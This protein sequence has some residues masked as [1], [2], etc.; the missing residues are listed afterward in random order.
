MYILIVDD[1]LVDRKLIKKMLLS[2]GDQYHNITEVTSVDEGLF[3]IDRTHFDVILLD[4]SMPKENGIK[5][6]SEMRAKPNLGNTAIVMISASE[7]EVLAL[8]C[9]EAGAQDFLP[10]NS[11]TSESLNKAILFAQKRFE[12]EQRMHESYLAVKRMAQRDQLT[13]LSNRY[14]FEEL[15]KTTIESNK[16][17][18]TSAALLALDLDNFKHINDTLGHNIGDE[19]LKQVVRRINNCLRRD[20]GFARLGGDEFAV[21]I[22]GVAEFTQIGKIAERILKHVAEPY[23]IENTIINCGVSIGSAIY[24]SDATE[25]ANLLKCADI[26][27][28]RSK[29][30]GKGR[31]S[32]YKEQYQYEFSRR[33]EIQ[34]KIKE[35]IKNNA[36]RL[37]YQPVFSTATNKV[38]GVEALIR[39]PDEEPYYTP[40]EF[41]PISEQCR[42]IDQLG[43]WVIATALAQLVIWQQQAESFSMSIN[44]S[45]VQLQND[46]LLAYFINCMDK[47]QL[48]PA[49]V[50]LEITETAFIE[51]D[52]KITNTLN[53][54]SEKGFRIALDDFGMGYSSIAHL[55]SYPID[56]VKLD[57]SLQTNGGPKA[58]HA[59]VIEG[60][61]LMLKAMGFAVVAEGV[62]TQEQY[63]F[64]NELDINHVQG[65]L[66]SKALPAEEVQLLF[67]KTNLAN[68]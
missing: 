28:Y 7:N 53:A 26:A 35:N 18:K 66:F 63:L 42:L 52:L 65:F 44:I 32:F 33:V 5:L 25:S 9:I 67:N 41:I 50:I 2:N 4:Y 57:K 49:N 64:C 27:M 43:E 24:P 68:S 36:F 60:L 20:E 22:S 17:S 15:L 10:K 23:L 31:I 29:Q 21:I 40:D 58:K 46:R 34:N 54:L 48:K 30:N 56:I 14:H 55:T 1:D 6:L 61:S 39:W 16:R 62:E 13:G 45:P 11:I 59:K 37:F 47:Y 19:V 38:T 12:A 3:A 8:K 51:D